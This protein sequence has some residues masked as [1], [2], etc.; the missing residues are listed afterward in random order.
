M[1]AGSTPSSFVAQ[2]GGTLTASDNATYTVQV[3][4]NGFFT[5]SGDGQLFI[6]SVTTTTNASGQGSFVLNDAAVPM[7][8]GLTFTATATSVSSNTSMFA[9]PIGVD[10]A[11]LIYV[12]NVYQLLLNRAPDEEGLQFWAG[13][14][15]NGSPAQSIVFGIADLGEY[16]N[17]QVSSLYTHYLGRSPDPAGQVFWSNFLLNGGT[18]EQVA[19]G[20]VSSNEYFTLEGSTNQ[21]FVQALYTE[22]LNRSPGTA[23]LNSWLTALNAG[24]SRSSVAVD[25]LTSTEYRTALVQNDYKLYLSRSADPG[26][27]EAWLVAFNAGSTDQQVLA[28]ILGSPEGFG[29][30]SKM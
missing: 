29:V 9:T 13:S 12:A 7:D 16:L 10:D 24:A 3:F 11:D 14:L 26:G 25:F 21:G 30:W 5:P 22:V 19:E 8:S 20:L 1:H 6:G 23:E 27:L 17:D 2:V 18:L 28:G 4:A 15:L